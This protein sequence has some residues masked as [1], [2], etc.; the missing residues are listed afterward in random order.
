MKIY[1]EKSGAQ[2]AL[3]GLNLQK[4]QSIVVIF[5]A[6]FVLINGLNNPLFAQFVESLLEQ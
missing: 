2:F 1:L 4:G 5:F 6:L 3:Q